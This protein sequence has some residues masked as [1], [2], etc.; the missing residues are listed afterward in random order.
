MNSFL[1]WNTVK[2]PV[3]VQTT[4]HI[5]CYNILATIP[6]LNYYSYTRK[7]GPPTRFLSLGALLIPSQSPKRRLT[8]PSAFRPIALTSC[9]CKVYGKAK[10]AF[11]FR[12]EGFVRRWT[13]GVLEVPKHDGSPDTPGALHFRGICQKRIHDRGVS[14]YPQSLRHDMATW[15]PYE[16]LHSCPVTCPFLFRISYNKYIT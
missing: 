12:S 9:P 10:A 13:V 7:Y 16:S 8:D 1:P 5:L 11:C 6:L 15:Y 3:P 2:A 4:F 14:R